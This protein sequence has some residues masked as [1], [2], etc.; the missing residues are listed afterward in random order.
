MSIL[1]NA[2]KETYTEVEAAE[3][4]NISLSRLRQL[5]DEYIFN[6]GR[7]RPEQVEFRLSDIILLE[8]WNRSTPSANVVRM[9]RR[10]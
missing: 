9:P 8:F 2:K 5:L 6:D 10:I 1:K 4:L 7:P 3:A